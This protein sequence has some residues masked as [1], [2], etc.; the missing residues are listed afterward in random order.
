MRK[1]RHLLAALAILAVLG[2]FAHGVIVTVHLFLEDRHESD[3]H[4]ADLESAIHGHAHE[5]GS[6]AHSH[7][8]TAPRA[9]S[10]IASVVMDPQSTDL[11]ATAWLVSAR[12]GGS[13]ATHSGERRSAGPLPPSLLSPIL[14]I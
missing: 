4:L 6:P 13:G 9:A 11:P 2:P 7:S 12:P 10:E 14:R 5:R 1:S 8:C 3:G